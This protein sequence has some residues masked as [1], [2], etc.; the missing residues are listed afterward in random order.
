MPA[1]FERLRVLTRQRFLLAIAIMVLAG[2][3]ASCTGSTALVTQ[4]LAMAPMA[5]M[6]LVVQQAP[7]TVQQAYQFAVAN[8]DLMKRIACYCGC[9]KVGHKSNYDCFV[10]SVDTAG[11][12]TFDQHALGCSICVDITQDAMRLLRQG[13]SMADISSNIDTTYAKY[14]PSNMAPPQ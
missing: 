14:G 5:Q 12:V 1:S 8:R 11:K 6:P 13:K 10:S 4:D 3:A 2:G 7:V 9:G